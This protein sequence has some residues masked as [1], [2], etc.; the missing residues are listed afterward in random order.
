[1]DAHA[2]RLRECS[3]A[4]IVSQLGA[5]GVK[6]CGVLLVHSAFRAV[7][8]VEGGPLGLIAAL[9]AALGPRGT[10]VLPSASEDD[11]HLFDPETTP[12]AASLG[13]LPALF[14]QQPGVQRGSHFDAFAAI[15]PKA[16]AI[17][18]APLRLPPAA[19]GSAID[20]IRGFGAQILLLGVGHHANSTAHLAELV[21]GAPYRVPRH[22]TACRDGKPH[23]IDYGEND[24]C[25]ARFELL[26]HW[27]RDAGLQ[28]EGTVGHARARLVAAKDVVRVAIEHLRLDPLIFLHAAGEGCAECDLA[29]AS[30]D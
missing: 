1:M 22:Y 26:D 11:D 28:R 14:W 16:K 17:A 5:L 23:R 30:V 29:R 12:P 19:P 2:N 27:L 3:Q 4:E 21:G 10:L 24:H 8:P 18:K 6:L 13:V 25:C 9:R 15:G 20:V 7:R